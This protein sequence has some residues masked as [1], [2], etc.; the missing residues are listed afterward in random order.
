MVKRYRAI[1]FDLFYT[2]VDLPGAERQM[3]IVE[4]ALG[5]ERFAKA[6]ALFLDWHIRNMG[7]GEYLQELDRQIRLTSSERA[8]VSA[9]VRDVRMMPYRD[10]V[11]T[12]EVLRQR[13]YKI[14]IVSNT[15]SMDETAFVRLGIRQYV[16]TIVLSCDVGVL[17]PDAKIFLT[18]LD[19]LGVEPAAALMVGDSLEKDVIG[20]VNAGM[21]AVLLDRDGGSKYPQRIRTLLELCDMLP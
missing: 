20:A 18:A 12:L 14:G 7:F 13:G 11:P 8:M 19:K 10:A 3:Y 16:D 15:N 2:L 5:A 1:L 9:W 21:D 4:E 17:K 6:H